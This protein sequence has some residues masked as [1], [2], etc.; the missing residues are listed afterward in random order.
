MLNTAEEAFR[1]PLKT[2]QKFYDDTAP[3]VGTGVGLG[4]QSYVGTGNSGAEYTMGINNNGGLQTSNLGSSVGYV[5]VTTDPTKSGLETHLT[6]TTLYLYFYV[7]ETVQNANLID[8]GRIGEVLATKTDML[9]ASGAGMPSSRYI[10]LTLGA[11][12]STY[13]APANGYFVLSKISNGTN[14]YITIGVGNLQITNYCPQ[15]GKWFQMI[16]PPVQKGQQCYVAYDLGGTTNWFRF[17]YAE[18]SK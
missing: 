16:T 10:D 9:Q 3:V 11:S 17:Y 14:Q 5:G 15:S 1:L 12:G 8:A 13:T 6:E 18:G 4:L 2:K 7:G